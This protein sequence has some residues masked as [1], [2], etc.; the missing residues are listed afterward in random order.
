MSPPSTI[1]QILEIA[2]ATGFAIAISD[3]VA[4]SPRALA[5]LRP[6]ERV[7]WCIS[8]LE[9][10]VNNGGFS[11]FFL[12]SAGDLSAETVAALH[13]IGARQA[14]ALL[15]EAMAVFPPPGPAPE[16]DVRQTQIDALPDSASATWEDLDQRFFGYPD[17]LTGLLRA[18]VAAHTGDF[19]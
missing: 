12:N 18:Y 2:D 10:E 17:D 8:E 4:R 14:A 11:L 7:V 3:L 5:E 9:R 6:A 1:D 13:T 15:T 16:Q 19:R